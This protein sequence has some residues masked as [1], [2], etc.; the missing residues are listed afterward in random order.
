MLKTLEHS[1]HFKR[2]SFEVDAPSLFLSFWK[3]NAETKKGIDGQEMLL[4]GLYSL[5]SLKPMTVVINNACN[6]Q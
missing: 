1:F 4:A 3:A 6:P 2:G 5:W